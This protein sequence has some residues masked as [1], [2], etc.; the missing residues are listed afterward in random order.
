M[1]E[2][3][4]IKHSLLENMKVML[5]LFKCMFMISSLAQITTHNVKNWL[6]LCKENLRCP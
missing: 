3:Q 5:Y 2:V 4:L 1:L 6:Q